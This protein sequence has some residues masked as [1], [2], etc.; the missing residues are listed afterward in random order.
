MNSYPLFFL[1]ANFPTTKNKAGWPWQPAAYVK[2]IIYEDAQLPKISIITP[3][4][5]QGTYLEETIRSVLLQNYP[6]LEYIIIDGGSTD[7]T[8]KVIKKYERWIAYWE[9]TP[10]KGQS[11]AINKGVQKASGDW[12]A[13]LNSDDIY[14]ENALTTIVSTIVQSPKTTS[15][16]VGTTI[17]TDSNLH[18]ISQF[19]PHLYTAPGRDKNYEKQGWID[20]VCTKRSGIALPQPSS[21]WKRDAVLQTGGLDESLRYA[22]DH[23]LYGRLA[24]QGFK[25]LL[26]DHTIACFRTHQEQ[27]TADFPFVFW[28]EE[29]KIVYNW[30]GQVNGIEKQ[31]LKDYGIWLE[32]Y[33]KSYPYRSIFYSLQSRLKRFLESR[34]TL[35]YNWIKKFSKK[36][37]A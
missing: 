36:E 20:F 9:S 7:D 37:E 32:R 8:V 30:I 28:K 24:N 21:F 4:Y 13:W 27:K 10:D 22:M 15:W 25:P 5:N 31:K 23:E 17:F 12:I 2:P 33:I 26:I 18:E 1:D 34:F 6:N 29:L 35:I 14:L 19:K 11:H 3:S 16:V